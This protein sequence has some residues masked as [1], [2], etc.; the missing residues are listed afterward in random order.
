MDKVMQ[1]SGP[2]TRRIAWGDRVALCLMPARWPRLRRSTNSLERLNKEVSR[3]CDVVGIF[4]SR[5]SLLRPTG[6]LLEEQNDEWAVGRR[7]LS[8]AGTSGSRPGYQPWVG[9][10]VPRAWAAVSL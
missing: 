1:V 10:G 7:Y 2:S 4:P 6:A 3:R 5:Q 9:W 8:E